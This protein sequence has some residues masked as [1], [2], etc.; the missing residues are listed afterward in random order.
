EPTHYRRQVELPLPPIDLQTLLTSKEQKKEEEAAGQNANGT[1]GLVA[2]NPE[3][4]IGSALDV[5]KI[6]M[7][8]GLSQS[9]IATI[10]AA[11]RN[12]PNVSVKAL[13]DQY[14]GLAEFVKR[15]CQ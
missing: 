13:L 9:D 15:E 14:P 12:S 5:N 11:A 8:A 6:S 10:T 4:E 7:V 1:N 2:Q 3:C